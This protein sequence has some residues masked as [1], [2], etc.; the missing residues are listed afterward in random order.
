MFLRRL[1]M[2]INLPW[3]TSIMS[4]CSPH[5]VLIHGLSYSVYSKVI[6]HM[7]SHSLKLMTLYVKLSMCLQF[8]K[9]FYFSSY[10]F[11]F[12]LIH[13]HV[14]LWV[15]LWRRVHWHALCKTFIALGIEIVLYG[16]LSNSL[17]STS[18]LLN[19]A[20]ELLWRLFLLFSAVIIACDSRHIRLLQDTWEV[21]NNWWLRD[22]LLSKS[23]VISIIGFSPSS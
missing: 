16:L 11:L 21:S 7:L 15:G 17:L 22:W 14:W 3:F 9:H 23:L 2:V 12:P 18:R 1:V 4:L 20:L 5:T 13:W 6:I 19:G 10:P 8:S